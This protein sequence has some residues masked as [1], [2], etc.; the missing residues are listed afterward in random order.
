MDV[1]FAHAFLLDPSVA[2][3]FSATNGVP[4]PHGNVVF[5]TVASYRLGY[6]V[7]VLVFG[8]ICTAFAIFAMLSAGVVSKIRASGL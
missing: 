8:V 2:G 7:K 1:V 6:S 3:A 5:C 4:I